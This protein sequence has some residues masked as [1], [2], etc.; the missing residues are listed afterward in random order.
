[1]SVYLQAS[2]K[3]GAEYSDCRSLGISAIHTENKVKVSYTYPSQAIVLG[4]AVE[5]Y[6]FC[7]HEIRITDARD[8]EESVTYFITIPFSSCCDTFNSKILDSQRN[9][10]G[11]I[12]TVFIENKRLA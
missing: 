7:E 11:C 12:K 8:D 2:M 6:K 10:V 3:K 9:T 1:M 4:N 5:I